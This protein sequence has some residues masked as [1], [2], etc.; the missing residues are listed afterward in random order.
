M[1]YLHGRR[2]YVQS[3]GVRAGEL[4]PFVVAVWTSSASTCR[5]TARAAST[6]SRTTIS[7][8]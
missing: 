4:D 7:T 8:S 2:V 6:S 1:K 5:A 3:A